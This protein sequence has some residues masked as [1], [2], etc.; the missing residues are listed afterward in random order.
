MCKFSLVFSR[1]QL[2]TDLATLGRLGGA[3]SN[4]V[5]SRTHVGIYNAFWILCS[6][7]LAESSHLPEMRKI[8]LLSNDV[9][10]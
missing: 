1:H 4:F 3:E 5:L 7:F 10:I 9:P 6:Y 8:T 2:N